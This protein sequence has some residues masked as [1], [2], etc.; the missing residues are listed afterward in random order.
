MLKIIEL[1]TDYLENPLG[2]DN[3]KPRFMWKI[4]SDK[5]NVMQQAYQIICVSEGRVIWDSRK[6]ESNE[7]ARVI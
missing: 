6:V 5:K 4:V 7:S 1:R 2:I 3:V